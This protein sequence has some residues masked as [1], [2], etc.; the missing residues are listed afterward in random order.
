MIANIL[1]L[2]SFA[3]G[4]GGAFGN[5]LFYLDQN[6]V[7]AYGLP[8][9]MIFALVFGILSK[10]HVLGKNKAINIIVSLVVGLMAV[11]LNFVSYFFSQI[12]PRLGV[13]LSII[14][15]AI[16][17]V[18]PFLPEKRDDKKVHPALVTI[19]VVGAIGAIIIIIQS[20]GNTGSWFTQIGSTWGFTYWFQTYGLVTLFWIIFIGL[21][22]IV[23]FYGNNGKKRNILG[24]KDVRRNR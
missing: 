14:L 19:G 11:Q 20:L 4:T 1:T 2:S 7:F 9:L 15:T 3:F 10:V 22:F 12:F 24:S 16:I 8:F 13:L 17:V 5:L 18:V 21:F 23:I 6:G